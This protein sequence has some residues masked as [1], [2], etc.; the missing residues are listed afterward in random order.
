MQKNAALILS[1]ILASILIIFVV[2]PADGTWQLYA[3]EVAANKKLYSELGLNQQ[4]LFVLI[5]LL[6]AKISDSIL[7]QKWIFFIIAF[8]YCYFIF[9][10]SIYRQN[11]LKSHIVAITAFAIAIQFEAYRFDDYHA[12]ADLFILMSYY[13]A[14]LLLDKKITLKRFFTLSIYIGVAA[15]LTRI[16]E[17]L[18]I[19]ASAFIIGILSRLQDENEKIDFKWLTLHSLIAIGLCIGMITLILGDS[20]FSWFNETLVKA[21]DAKGGG[22]I[23]LTP[24]ILVRECLVFL[25][26]FKYS[27][28]ITITITP[29]C[30]LY[31]IFSTI[32]LVIFH[33]S[34]NYRKHWLMVFPAS[35]FAT[36]VLSSGGGFYGLY[37]GSALTL[38]TFH[39]CYLQSNNK[40]RIDIVV[41]C[42]LLV[43][44]L[45]AL[46]HKIKSPY[47]WHDYKLEPI[48][49][50]YLVKEDAKGN[51][52]V[53]SK[54]LA[55]TIDPVCELTK[56]QPALLSMPYSFANYYCGVPVWHGVIQSFFDTSTKSTVERILM[57]L[58]ND[59]PKYIWYQRQLINLRNHEVIF[60]HGNPLP[61]RKLDEFIMD[62]VA[63]KKWVVVYSSDTY[64]PSDWMLIDTRPD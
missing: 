64:S 61:H 43:I 22:A 4:P 34:I 45:Q 2:G 32:V 40:K 63:N 20:P 21:K 29:A 10:I 59:T 25:Y 41:C 11:N 7:Y 35:Y 23:Y 53:I 42:V 58:K 57:G 62:N 26:E 28:N 56:N 17:G 36:A 44:A 52:Y 6:S 27:S 1:F 51:P 60:N 37:F 31:A 46:A 16:N 38:L 12:L 50:K 14:I 9:K 3:K 39:I 15:F 19:F 18:C 30:A 49:K 47:S 24:L 33:K 54:K 55:M 13:A 48:G 5:N 8:A